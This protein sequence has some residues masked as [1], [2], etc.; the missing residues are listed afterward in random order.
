[1][2][3]ILTFCFT[4]FFKTLVQAYA[5]QK[6]KIPVI[7]RKKPAERAFV[8]LKIKANTEQWCRNQALKQ[9]KGSDI[10]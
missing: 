8:F 2:R 10:Y 6:E 4:S 5:K 9:G 7:K 1:M 3:E